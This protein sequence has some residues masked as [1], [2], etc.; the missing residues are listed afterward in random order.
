[1]I[2]MIVLDVDGTLTDGSITFIHTNN[3]IYESKS[4]NTKDGLGI[5]LWIKNGGLV[6]IISGRKCH[7]TEQRAKELG[8]HEIHLGIDDKVKCLE[9]S[10]K[11]YH[12]SPQNLACIGDDLNDLGMY[13][14]CKYSFAPSDASARNLSKAT[15]I[16]KARGGRG[17]VREM[18]EMLNAMQG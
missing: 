5:A 18:I 4:F 7:L 12:L 14:F 1:M 2:K 15:F 6:S 11:K 13:E 3:G 9:E 16:T 10:I 17:A 8:V